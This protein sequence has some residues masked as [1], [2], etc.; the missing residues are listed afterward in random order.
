MN[1]VQKK[2]LLMVGWGLEILVLLINKVIYQLLEEIR[3]WLLEVEKIFFLNRY[4][5]F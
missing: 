4:K 1:K 5:I 3:I 2:V